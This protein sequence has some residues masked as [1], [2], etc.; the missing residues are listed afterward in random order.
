MD[1]QARRASA[2]V[3]SPTLAA[4]LHDGLGRLKHSPCA[5]Q[6]KV[7]RALLACRT[8]QLGGEV[9]RCTHCGGDHFRPFACRN[10]HC[11]QCQGHLATQ[12]LEVQQSRVLPVPY[13]HLVFTLPH[14]LNPLIQQN[15]SSLLALLFEAASQT[16][17]QFGRER[18]QA[19]LGLTMVLHT[20]GQNLS[21]HYHV[22]VIV[23]GGGLNADRSW[24]PVK[25][26]HYLFP[27]RAL[28]A[29][30]RGKFCGGLQEFFCKGK[31][32]FHGQ[33]AA[34]QVEATFQALI[35][36]VTAKPWVLYAKRPFAG[37]ES[38]LKYLSAY[39]HRVAISNRRLLD[40]NRQTHQV[41]FRYRDYAN[42]QRQKT[43]TLDTG[44]F[45]RRFCLHILPAGFTKIRHYGLL[46]NRGR[47][48]R[49]DQARR[50]LGVKPP[51]EDFPATND[52]TTEPAPSASL[53][54]AHTCPYCGAVAL[55]WIRTVLPPGCRQ[56]GGDTS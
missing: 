4:V 48:E 38:V 36:E 20:W 9:Y 21:D 28:S 15:R 29:M 17:L 19:Q 6:W 43:M 23:T 47:A 45:A 13:F 10:R 11:P 51:G 34:L 5:Q 56:P 3:Q 7:L 24:R 35:R 32:Q 25:N 39:T 18:L 54:E 26:P 31:L 14:A 52:L 42:G 22:H 1:G 49:L 40:L 55:H 44:E 27:I 41:R 30:Y 16:L 2:P 46:A 12:W 50:A 53:D 33:L 37:P 8:G